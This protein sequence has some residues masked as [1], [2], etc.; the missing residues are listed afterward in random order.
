M[1]AALFWLR[2]A[3]FF[4]ALLGAGLAFA[5]GIAEFAGYSLLRGIYSA[6]RL[7]E[8]ATMA[9]IFFMG[10]TLRARERP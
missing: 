6:G 2:R 9:M 5:E 3:A 7:L 4:A 8:F 1:D 10:L